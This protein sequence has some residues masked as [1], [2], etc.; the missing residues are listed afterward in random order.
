M[1][2]RRLSDAVGTTA[3]ALEASIAVSSRAPARAA[4]A[5]P[6]APPAPVPERPDL[7][8]DDSGELPTR[9]SIVL[10]LQ[11]LQQR[12]SG[13]KLDAAAAKEIRAGLMGQARILNAIDASGERKRILG[14][15][16]VLTDSSYADLVAQRVRD[17]ARVQS[18]QARQRQADLEEAGV[19]A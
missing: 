16:L 10:Q 3:T 7:D 4:C 14:R 6:S 12:V 18:A 11:G 5:A 2:R 15:V 9:E 17:G 8:P 1:A 19:V 13:G